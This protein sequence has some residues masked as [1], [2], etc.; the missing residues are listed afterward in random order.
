MY[1]MNLR[2]EEGYFSCWL[3]TCN[4]FIIDN[5]ID[6]KIT[7]S[8]IG[9]LKVYFSSVL[10]QCPFSSLFFLTARDHEIN[11]EINTL[12]RFLSSILI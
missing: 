10:S 2:S 6:I 7:S 9:P 3:T 1:F 12:V 11:C 4:K 5:I 8:K